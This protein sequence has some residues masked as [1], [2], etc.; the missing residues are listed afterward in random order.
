MNMSREAMRKELN[1][2]IMKAGSA[3]HDASFPDFPPSKFNACSS[4]KP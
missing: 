1:L 4:K 3:G 2:E